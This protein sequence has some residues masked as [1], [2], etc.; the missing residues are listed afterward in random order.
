VSAL[1]S[2]CF[3]AET[4]Q[5]SEEIREMFHPIIRKIGDLISGQIGQVERAGYQVRVSKSAIT[6][7]ASGSV[8]M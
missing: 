5:N 3:M 7:I 1:T 6:R 2:V 8:S 4:D